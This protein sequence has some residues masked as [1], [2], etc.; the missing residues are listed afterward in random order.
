MNGKLL[1][2]FG[3]PSLQLSWP[4]KPETG[5][6]TLGPRKL[7]ET[8]LARELNVPGKM[9]TTFVH[10][11]FGALE[12]VQFLADGGLVFRRQA[13]PR[14]VRPPVV[15]VRLRHLNVIVETN[16]FLLL[17]LVDRRP[18]AELPQ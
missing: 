1:A 10:G 14:F 15:V 5:N 2:L 9:S 7:A 16:N 8:K 12:L 11:H 18:E 17:Q 3:L 13:C 4:M 6:E